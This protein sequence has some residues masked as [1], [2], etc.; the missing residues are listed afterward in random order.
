MLLGGGY[1]SFH[2][3]IDNNTLW[4]VPTL[5][6]TNFGNEA[7]SSNRHSAAGKVIAILKQFAGKM[8][9]L[10]ADPSAKCLRV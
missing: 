10:P 1:T 2:G 9:G 8:Q 5:Y 3:L 4:M 6:A 7:S